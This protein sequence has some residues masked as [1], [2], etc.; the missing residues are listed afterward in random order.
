[1]SR[2]YLDYPGTLARVRELRS[3][4]EEVGQ[5]ASDLRDLND[6]IPA[7]WKGAAADAYREKSETLQRLIAENRQELDSLA[8]RIRRIAEIIHEQDLRD[9]QAARSL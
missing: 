5:I 4:A 7:Y 3:I 6:G 8:S 2:L 9:A 1:M